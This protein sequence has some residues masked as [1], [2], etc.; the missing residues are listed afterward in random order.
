[1]AKSRTL[2]RFVHIQ[3]LQT[4]SDCVDGWVPTDV[5]FQSMQDRIL[6]NNH[7][8][9]FPHTN[10][11]PS[12]NPEIRNKTSFS[13]FSHRSLG[14]IPLSINLHLLTTLYTTL[15]SKSSSHISP[16]FPSLLVAHTFP[17]HR[18]F[19]TLLSIH[20]YQFSEYFNF[21][22]PDIIFIYIF[23]NCILVL[24]LR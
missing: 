13:T 17:V 15:F 2:I 16:G 23:L 20:S 18:I 4:C 19:T 11:K 7:N 10:T 21:K 12:P 14:T 1:L 8:P 22:F 24:F 9:F 5:T 3:L 6:S